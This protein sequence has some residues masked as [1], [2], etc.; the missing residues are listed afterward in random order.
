[1]ISAMKCIKE[2]SWRGM[3]KTTLTRQTL[4]KLIVTT[5][6]GPRRQQASI[7]QQWVP[8]KLWGDKARW[9]EAICREV[10][11]QRLAIS[12][13]KCTWTIS[14]ECNRLMDR[15]TSST[16]RQAR[17]RCQKSD[18]HSN[19]SHIQER[20][21]WIK[22]QMAPT[23]EASLECSNKRPAPLQTM[24]AKTCRTT[25]M[26]TSYLLRIMMLLRIRQL[27]PH[28]HQTWDPR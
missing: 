26:V 10:K 11:I 14:S 4:Q 9:S 19:H 5:E 6:M 20:T 12:K 3:L 23:W 22:A 17:S 13:R 2:A 1:M 15:A 27:L 8:H 25:L 18:W 28:R 21:C 24:T 16:E 7:C